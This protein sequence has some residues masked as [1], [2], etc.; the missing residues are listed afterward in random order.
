MNLSF[1][2]CRTSSISKFGHFCALYVYTAIGIGL[3]IIPC[4]VG[5]ELITSGV[6]RII[7]AGI[8]VLAS[9]ASI[10]L[11]FFLF[12]IGRK[13][14]CM[15]TRQIAITDNGFIIR[16]RTD[17]GYAWE[18]VEGI[19]IIVYAAN[20]SNQIYQT[21]ICIFLEPI[22]DI[23][24]RKLR[25]S[26]LHGALGHDKYVLL[27]YNSFIQDQLKMYANQPVIDFRL[28]QLSL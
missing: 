12:I 15:E 24:L 8:L 18:S 6:D 25:D 9:M 28:K 27:D 22:S 20:A 23:V 21:Q 13:C 3:L 16:D 10:L 11:V 17:R 26:Y 1:F 7:Q 4:I 14:C 5:I 19:G 2:P